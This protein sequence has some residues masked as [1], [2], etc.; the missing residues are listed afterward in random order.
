M[1]LRLILPYLLVKR[2][3][4]LLLQRFQS[5]KAA[6]MKLGIHKSPEAIEEFES[7]ILQVREMKSRFRFKR[8]K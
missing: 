3:E 1:V 2:D 4:A 5:I 8:S 6:K 7:L